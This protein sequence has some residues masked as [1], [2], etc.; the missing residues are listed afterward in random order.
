MHMKIHFRVIRQN[1]F[2]AGEGPTL[3]IYKCEGHHI[4]LGHVLRCAGSMEKVVRLE[5]SSIY[6][7]SIEPHQILLIGL[8]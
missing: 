6:L 8:A 2:K 4:I 7:L 3:S 1:S 5:S